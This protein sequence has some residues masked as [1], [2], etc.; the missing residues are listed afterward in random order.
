M[1]VSLLEMSLMGGGMVL[2]TLLIKGLARGRLPQGITAFMWGAALM[3]LVL[4][5]SI[6]SPVSLLGLIQGVPQMVTVSDLQGAVQTSLFKIEHL[7]LVG[8]IVC[9]LLFLLSVLKQKSVLDTALPVQMTPEMKKILAMQ[10]LSQSPGIYT[11]D[12]ICTPLVYG[13]L[14]PRIILPAGMEIG[15]EALHY[16]ITHECVHIKRHDALKK[17]LL[18]LVVCLH[19]FNPLIWLMAAIVRRDMELA[20]DE[21]VLMLCGLQAR[22]AYART[23]LSLEGGKRFGG[24]LADHFSRSPLEARIRSIMTVKKA[25]LPGSLAAVLVYGLVSV[26]LAASPQVQ[27]IIA[28]RAVRIPITGSVSWR[29]P[30]RNVIYA[31]NGDVFTLAQPSSI[32]ISAAGVTAEGG[33][34]TKAASVMNTVTVYGSAPAFPLEQG[35]TYSI[36]AGQ[37]APATVTMFSEIHP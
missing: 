31:W 28:I 13:L 14:R 32:A 36:Y 19:W 12:R 6:P 10:K 11:S 24:I 26:A 9:A 27:D 21:K 37:A 2:L 17:L 29:Q 5:F 7:L 33:L 30:A 8:T 35:A 22:A 34:T 25:A 3:R 20:C 18:M 1:S 4:P 15:S 23:L 16:V